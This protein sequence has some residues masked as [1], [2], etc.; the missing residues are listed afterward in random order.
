MKL[1]P[2]I[3]DQTPRGIWESVFGK[4][5]PKGN[6]G[7]ETVRRFLKQVCANTSLSTDASDFASSGGGALQKEKGRTK[8]LLRAVSRM[9]ILSGVARA[10]I[11]SKNGI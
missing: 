10:V 8:S 7:S 3:Y 1:T 9:N 2:G 11:C 6:E 5:D 4:D